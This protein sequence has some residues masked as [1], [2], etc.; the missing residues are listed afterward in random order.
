MH[1]PC[2]GDCS[3]RSVVHFWLLMA[4]VVFRFAILNDL[5]LLGIGPY[6]IMGLVPMLLPYHSTILAVML[7]DSILP[8]LFGLC[9]LFLSQ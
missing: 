9:C 3:V 4:W 2:S 7:F 1:L 8:G 6:W 5:L